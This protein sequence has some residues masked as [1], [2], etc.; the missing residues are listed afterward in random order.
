MF[1][2]RRRNASSRA[3]AGVDLT[4][5]EPSPVRQHR[6]LAVLTALAVAVLLAVGGY[7]WFQ[8]VDD[9]VAQDIQAAA[10]AAEDGRPFAM[11]DAV[12]NQLWDGIYVFGP[13]VSRDTMNEQVGA[14]YSRFP[15][16]S[17]ESDD[18]Q[19]VVFVRDGRPVFQLRMRRC[20][21]DFV[22]EGHLL[23]VRKA[24][25]RFALSPSEECLRATLLPHK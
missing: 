15:A 2:D 8:R 4:R 7:A 3:P 12:Q 20:H 17:A 13:G 23:G 22:A 14:E 11:T 10:R 16:V 5:G 21:P 9:E 1:A 25:A 6:L 19:L 24:D 18:E